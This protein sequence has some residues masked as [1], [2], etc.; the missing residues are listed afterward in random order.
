VTPGAF[1]EAAEEFGIPRELAMRN[2]EGCIQAR[3]ALY[4]PGG[5]I[6]KEL[7]RNPTVLVVNDTAFA[8]GGLLPTHGEP[9]R[10]TASVAGRYAAAAQPAEAYPCCYINWRTIACF[11]NGNE[12]GIALFYCGVLQC[13]ASLVLN[14]ACVLPLPCVLQ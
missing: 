6:A 10:H 14:H 9:T 3:A 2:W 4:L 1:I 8:H 7:S 13:L 11:A 5:R 12:S